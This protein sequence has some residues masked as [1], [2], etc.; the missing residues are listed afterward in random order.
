M[1]YYNFTCLYKT[2]RCIHIMSKRVRALFAKHTDLSM[3]WILEFWQNM[4]G[5]IIDNLQGRSHESN[6]GGEPSH[7][8]S[9]NNKFIY[10]GV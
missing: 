7:I 8:K 10:N 2:L 4:L 5:S 6:L 9:I 1:L 3:K